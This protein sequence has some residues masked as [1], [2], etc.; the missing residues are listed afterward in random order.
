MGE[1][2]GIDRQRAVAIG[3]DADL[4]QRFPQATAAIVTATS[5]VIGFRVA[6]T[7]MRFAGLY[8]SG[9]VIRMGASFVGLAVNAMNA[10][11]TV[12]TAFSTI[13]TAMTGGAGRRPSRTKPGKHT[14]A[15]LQC[16]NLPALGRL[17]VSA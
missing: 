13:S 9:G 15:L 17:L 12:K 10:A 6:I 16:E 14:K 11:S 1:R 5:T 4:A 2:G 7:A 8:A 3:L